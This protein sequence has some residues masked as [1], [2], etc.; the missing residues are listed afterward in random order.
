MNGIST[1]EE[2]IDKKMTQVLFAGF[3]QKISYKSRWIP[4][5]PSSF[6]RLVHSFTIFSCIRKRTRKNI[7]ASIPFSTCYMKSGIY[8]AAIVRP[9]SC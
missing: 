3:F 8:V 2:E 1:K 5:Y 4:Q 7:K 6:N 9:I